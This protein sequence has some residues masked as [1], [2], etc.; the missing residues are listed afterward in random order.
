[1]LLDNDC[2]SSIEDIERLVTWYLISRYSWEQKNPIITCELLEKL[3][4]K[5]IHRKDEL[6]ENHKKYVHV[7][8]YIIEVDYPSRIEHM[9]D[10]WREIY[11]GVRTKEVPG[12]AEYFSE[13]MHRGGLQINP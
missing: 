12:A 1:M 6:S 10:Q 13:K 8:G 11:C 5:I 3:H 9:S 4:E 7:R 2:L